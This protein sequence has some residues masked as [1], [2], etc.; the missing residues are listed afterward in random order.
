MDKP[1]RKSTLPCSFVTCLSLKSDLLPTSKRLTLS[2]AYSSMSRTQCFTL[3]NESG[4][5]TS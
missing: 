5:V 3:A 1:K 4:L 2:E